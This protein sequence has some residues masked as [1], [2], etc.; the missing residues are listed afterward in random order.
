[1]KTFVR[2]ALWTML[3]MV[4]GVA[5]LTRSIEMFIEQWVIFHASR[6]APS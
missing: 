3:A 4:G 1:M 6:P 5:T 2:K